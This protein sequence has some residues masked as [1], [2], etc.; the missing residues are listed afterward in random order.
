VFEPHRDAA[1]GQFK[2]REGVPD[3]AFLVM[4]LDVAGWLR[5]EVKT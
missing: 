4:V 1:N 2:P 3:A 5:C